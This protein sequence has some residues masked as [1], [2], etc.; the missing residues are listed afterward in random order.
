[1]DQQAIIEALKAHK[2]QIENAHAENFALQ[3][4]LVGLMNHMI[5][6]GTDR[7]VIDDAF[8]FAADI[9]ISN[10]NGTGNAHSLRVIDEL[11]KSLISH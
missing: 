9:C 10:A 2:L 4:I 3:S 6:S 8:D 5:R 7:K 11:H 1:M